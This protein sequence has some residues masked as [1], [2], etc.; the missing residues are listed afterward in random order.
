ME[1]VSWE[2]SHAFAVAVRAVP[3]VAAALAVFKSSSVYEARRVLRLYVRGIFQ[4]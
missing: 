3:P 2:K 1:G 4:P